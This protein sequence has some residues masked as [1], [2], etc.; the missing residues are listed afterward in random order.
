MHLEKS[1]LSFVANTYCAHIR[2]AQLPSLPTLQM[3]T[4][5]SLAAHLHVPLE[6]RV[7][8]CCLL[9]LL[10]TTVLAALTFFT[11]PT[12]GNSRLLATHYE[13]RVMLGHGSLDLPQ[14]R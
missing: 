1:I 10:F 14:D 9:A 7:A 8:A 2:T 5:N 11:K 4:I 12:N 6:H 13:I 3:D